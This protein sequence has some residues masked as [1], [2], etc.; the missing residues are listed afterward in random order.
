MSTNL[1]VFRRWA[2]GAASGGL[3]PTSFSAQSDSETAGSL[4]KD[5]N[6]PQF[7]LLPAKNWMNDPNGPIYFNGLYHM[8]FQ[9]N[10][11][12]A[13]W[14]N[15]SWNHATSIDMLHWS[16]QPLAFTPTP[17]SPDAFGCFSGSS[18]Q[19]GN[20]VYV[21]YTG[22]ELTKPEFATLRDGKVTARES[23]CLAWSDDPKL[24]TWTK[25]P[26]P[27]VPVPPSGLAVTGF[28]DPSVW[29]QNGVYYMTVGSGAVNVGGCVLLY[30]S[31]DLRNWRYL[32]PLLS[33]E[34]N[35][36][37]TTNPCDDGEMW[38]CPELFPL[39]AG[40]VLIYSTLG[41]VFW[42]SGRLDPETMTF[43][44]ARKGV[45]DL[46]SYYAPKTQIDAHGR[47]ILWGWIQEQR[48]EAAMRAAGWSGM[49]SLPR[50]LQL[51][52]D[53]EL[54]MQIVPEVAKLRSRSIPITAA[55]DTCGATL[56]RANG[57]ILC[58][59]VTG[60]AMS[61]EMHAEDKLLLRIAYVPG[62]HL[63]LVNGTP[64]PLQ[65]QDLP[66][67]QLFV[68]ASVVEVILSERIGY[69]TRF[70]HQTTETPNVAISTTGV[71][72][73]QLQAWAIRPISADRL[74]S[75]RQS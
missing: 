38:E 17:G 4:A 61:F 68:D 58:S 48:S 8:F 72:A 44:P 28:R 2:V 49:M 59:G 22:T 52:A 20:R 42:L 26:K 67:L 41:K 57:E 5:G 1:R 35:G 66:T 62:K 60:K 75:L 23:Q 64:F 33:G 19:I 7:H 46:G 47:R 70:Y 51:D 14:G 6:R 43:I 40:H 9:Y 34:W 39:D 63:F 69:T 31:K 12:A 3:R 11:N 25:D 16:H 27:V 37:K 65:P 53:G 50:R 55:Q 56:P 54:R 73:S 74:T 29:K 30:R 36:K 71:S 13:V 18:I 10:P 21:V 24:I 32:H 15:M 45:L